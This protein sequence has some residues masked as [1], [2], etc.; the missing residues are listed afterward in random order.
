M[1]GFLMS[2]NLGSDK[3]KSSDLAQINCNKFSD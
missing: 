2:C 1:Q 3:L